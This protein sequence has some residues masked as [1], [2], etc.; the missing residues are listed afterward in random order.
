MEI[1]IKDEP[2]WHEGTA[3]DSLEKI[4]FV[5]KMVSLKEETKSEL[6]KP[7]PFEGNFELVSEMVLLKQE[8]K[9]ELIEPRPAEENTFKPSADSKEEVLVEQD[10][11]ELPVPNIKEENM[12]R[13]LSL[14]LWKKTMMPVPWGQ[15]AR[16]RQQGAIQ[17]LRSHSPL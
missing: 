8:T 10:K 7:S 6:I 12:K 4:E 2:V 16:T 9:S 13:T 5:S 14:F 3:N 17:V 15:Q 11:V 1:E